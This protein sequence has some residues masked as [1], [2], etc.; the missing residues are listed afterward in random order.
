MAVPIESITT[1]AQ[2]LEAGD[3][4]RCEMIRG[5]VVR[6]PYSVLERG[7]IATQLAFAMNEHVAH[8]KLGVVAIA[9]CGYWIGC[10]PDTVRAPDVGFIQSARAPARGYRGYIQGPPDL[11]VEVLSPDDRAREVS[12]RMQQWL[13]AGAVS[14][15]VVDPKSSTVTVYHSDQNAHIFAMRDTLSDE[16]VLPGFS[17]AV[18]A[19]FE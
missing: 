14:V 10:D 18:A 1:A 19:I 9:D 7:M 17:T 16:G 2:L 13:A 15:W 12:D 3:I 11:A 4:G 8:R 6:L 5:R